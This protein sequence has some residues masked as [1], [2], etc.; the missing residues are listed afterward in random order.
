[1]PVVTEQVSVNGIGIFTRS[2][3]NGNDDAIVI[4]GGP[5]AGHIS[6]TPAFD[7]LARG[8]RIL[9][10]DQRGCGESPVSPG[11]PIGWRQHVDDL[12][13][14]IDRW[15][16]ERATIIGH[17]WGALL[18]LMFAI[19]AP[20]RIQQM[21]LVTPAAV[22]SEDRDSYLAELSRRME[23]LGIM[24]KQRDLLSSGLRKSDP[25][26]FRLRAFKLTLEPYL[27]DPSK[28]IAVQP[29]QISHPARAAV[30]RSLGD[31]DFTSKLAELSVPALVIHGRHD[32]TPISSSRRIAELL[33]APLHVFEESG[34]MPFFEEPEHFFR[35]C[36]RFLEEARIEK[37]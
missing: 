16:I 5:S 33:G 28:T 6:L 1:M 36:E 13:Q 8:R 18:G 22:K 30:W 15:Q 10:Y 14:L 21:L 32:P 7:E 24:K 19:E 34:H 3:G 17:S 12:G 9:Y 2:V 4:H 37:D 25:N 29:F 20:A 11:T 31:Y 27:K 35:V 23:A 26:E